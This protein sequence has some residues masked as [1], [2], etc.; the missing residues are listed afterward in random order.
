[1]DVRPLL[2]D[3]QRQY[4][5]MSRGLDHAHRAGPGDHPA[6]AGHPGHRHSL[7]PPR[8][9]GQYGCGPRHHLQR[10]ARTGHR[11]RLERGG[12]RRVR[13]R[14][15]QHQGALRPVRG[16]LR[17]A[18]QPA[19]QRDHQLRREVLSAQGRPQRA[20]RPAAAASADL[21]RRQWREAHPADHRQI[22]PALEF[23]RRHPRMSSDTSARCW[24][25][26]APTSAAT[27]RRS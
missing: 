23:R 14:A 20:E 16:G 15:G 10:T 5:A 21:H 11:R 17:G 3:L 18:D 1:M 4:R 12:V 13:H 26:T 6:A 25:R 27:R 7:P 22:R 19:Q 24:R 2:S 8:G 9:A